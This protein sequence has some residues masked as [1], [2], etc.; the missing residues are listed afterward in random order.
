MRRRKGIIR[1]QKIITSDF[2]LIKL[3]ISSDVTATRMGV[4]VTK[5]SID[6]DPKT[7]NRIEFH[8]KEG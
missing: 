5:S 1:G 6:K 7:L 3:I 2:F 4:Q 8:R